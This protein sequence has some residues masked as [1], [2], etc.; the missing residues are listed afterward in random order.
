MR[1][2]MYSDLHISRTSSIMPLTS[3]INKYTYR[4]NMIL[5]LG[6][7]LENIIDEQK[8]DLIINL[9]DTF[10]NHTITSYDIDIASKFFECF[11]MLNIPHIVLV[12]NH[13]MINQDFNAIEILNNINNITVISEPSTVNTD[14]ILSAKLSLQQPNVKL[15]FLPYCDYRDILEF[16]EGDFLFS[17]QDIQGSCIRGDFKLPNGINQND[18]SKYKLVFNGHIHKSSIMKNIINVGSI[19]THSFSDDQENVPKCYIFDTNTLDLTTYKPTCCPLFRKVEIKKN[20]S[21]L[22]A[23]MDQLDK[24]YKYILH[25]ICPFELKDEIKSYIEQNEFVINSRIS[26]IGSIKEVKEENKNNTVNLS[27]N[28]DILQNFKDFLNITDLKY[29]LELYADVLKEVK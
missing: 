19:S 13:E 8:P 20:I 10:D 22:Y 27:S 24:N 26:I 4:Q 11:R 17:H 18:L 1:I 2:F 16:P 29:P 9:G 25:I 28:I 7:Y 23:F 3:S 12:G 6:K 5:E 14:I 21:E 15:A